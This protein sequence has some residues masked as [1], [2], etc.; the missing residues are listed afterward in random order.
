MTK[1]GNY[2]QCPCVAHYMSS[3][4]RAH[5]RVLTFRFN[6]KSRPDPLFDYGNFDHSDFDYG[7][8]LHVDHVRL[9]RRR[10]ERQYVA[11]GRHDWAC[12]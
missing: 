6:S 11:L 7:N 4:T 8:M 3:R 2:W 10:L 9:V 5:M 1:H 12:W